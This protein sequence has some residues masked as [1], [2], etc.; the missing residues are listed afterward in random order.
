M[1][2]DDKPEFTEIR[3]RVHDPGDFQSKTFR[4]VTLKKDKPRVFAVMGKLKGETTM[5]IQALRFPKSDGWTLSKAKDWVSK[6][7]MKS[8]LLMDL[9]YLEQEL[10]DAQWSVL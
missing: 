6:H 7:P 10:R 4:R 1:P 9:Q 3:Y 2:W 5:T 8:T